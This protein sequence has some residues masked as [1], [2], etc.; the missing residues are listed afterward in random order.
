MR[1]IKA[2]VMAAI[3][4]MPMAASSQTYTM[5]VNLRNGG[6]TS[7]DAGQVINVTF[8]ENSPLPAD[9]GNIKAE[10]NGLG[11]YLLSVAPISNAETY[12]WMKD[13]VTVQES[14]TTCF[15][16]TETG[17]YSVVGVNSYGEGRAS[18]GIRVSPI[19]EDFNILTEEFIP[20]RKLREYIKNN[21][22]PE[23]DELTNLQAAGINGGFY[24]PKDIE[25]LK[26][27]EYFT[28]IDSLLTF[29]SNS[30]IREIDLSKNVSL[31]KIALN[32][33][34]NLEKLNIDG[35]N[36]LEAF[37]I[38]WTKLNKYDLSKLPAGLKMLGLGHVRYTSLDV[39]RFEQLEELI[40][41]DNKLTGTLDLSGMKKLQRIQASSNASLEKL[42]VTGCASL[43]NLNV[44]YCSALNS[45][46]LSTCP[47]LEKLFMMY[48]SLPDIDIASQ[49]TYM[50]D[51]LP[52]GS[53]IKT[54]NLT[55]MRRLEKLQAGECPLVE[56]P[57]FSDC[58]ALKNLRMEG[59]TLK[60][61]V[62]VASC[63]NMEDI[64][65]YESAITSIALQDMPA[66]WNVNLFSNHNLKTLELGNLPSLLYLMCYDNPEIERV[67]ISTVNHR[68]SIYLG[69]CPKLKEIK[70]WPDFDINNPPTN[71]GKDATA[72]FV[73]EFSE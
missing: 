53:P 34:F 16:A 73:Y 60:E 58:V 51:Y 24:L 61:P 11:A 42:D 12:K 72:K 71:I 36:Q 65:I 67:D 40:I 6:V 37:D 59:T 13:G 28:A 10:V 23:S 35:L 47:A 21:F 4:A 43:R 39:S 62:N 64:N 54:I 57:D 18:S 20:D 15:P 68:A 5:E 69:S 44:S 38:S 55:G 49:S 17:V 22:A 30:Y 7:I 32:D 70:V 25:S 8:S 50:T 56:M 45:L 31:K 66:L 9:A 48:T 27:I 2:L 41:Y 29:V 3:M 19:T 33:Y 14:T 46:D 26:G 1:K 52:Q 63:K